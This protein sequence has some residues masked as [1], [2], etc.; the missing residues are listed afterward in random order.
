MQQNLNERSSGVLNRTCLPSDIIAFV[1]FCR[2][3]YRLTLRGI[4]VSYEAVR[5]WEAKL[6][7]V[8]GDELRKRRRGTGRQWVVDRLGL[9]EWDDKCYRS[10]RRIAPSVGLGRLL[11]ASIRRLAQSAIT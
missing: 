5:D 11:P 9:T 10:C 8:M 7:P 1:V 6:L 2:L 3:R 4:E